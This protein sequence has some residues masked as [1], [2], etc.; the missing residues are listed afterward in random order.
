[1]LPMF[2]KWWQTFTDQLRRPSRPTRRGT[3]RGAIAFRPALE[4]LERRWLPA[5]FQWTGLSATSALWSDPSNWRNTDT[6]QTGVP[7]ALDDLVF[8]AGAARLTTVDNLTVGTTFNSLKFFG[9]GYVIQG[10]DLSFPISPSNRI[11]LGP[12]GITASAPGNSDVVADVDI[13]IDVTL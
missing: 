2:R 9:S 5:T 1:A 3:A 4:S 8:P 13:Q 12:G 6:N 10:L 7:A 11:T